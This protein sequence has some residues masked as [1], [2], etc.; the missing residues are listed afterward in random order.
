MKPQSMENNV[1]MMTIS[2]SGFVIES[3]SSF[4]IR[5][6][7]FFHIC[8]PVVFGRVHHGA[9]SLKLHTYT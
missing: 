7:H 2:D 3:C 8:G 1:R 6:V 5:G 4:R 9:E